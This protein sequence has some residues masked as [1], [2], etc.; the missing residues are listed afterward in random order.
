MISAIVLLIIVVIIAILVIALV[1]TENVK[2]NGKV[3]Q[4][5]CGSKNMETEDG[6]NIEAEDE[7]MYGEIRYAEPEVNRTANTL[8]N[9]LYAKSPTMPCSVTVE[10]DN[11]DLPTHTEILQKQ[12][13]SITESE[14][15]LNDRMSDNSCSSDDQIFNDNINNSEESQSSSA[16]TNKIITEHVSNTASTI[17]KTYLTAQTVSAEPNVS[18]NCKFSQSSPS[19]EAI[20]Y[21]R[22]VP[23]VPNPA[24]NLKKHNKQ[25][26][27]LY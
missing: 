16:I 20:I 26:R 5:C 1:L 12:L 9:P 22:L 24:C 2:H 8:P 13:N 15:G 17:K 3:R 21:E 6:P 19:T 25:H 4:G 11:A 10:Y 7:V 27:E 18:Y 14:E 23:I